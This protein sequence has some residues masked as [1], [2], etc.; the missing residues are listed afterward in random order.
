MRLEA[1]IGDKPELEALARLDTCVTV[2]DTAN[3]LDVFQDHRYSLCVRCWYKFMHYVRFCAYDVES[4]CL[5]A[6][7]LLFQN[8][9]SAR[10]R[11][12]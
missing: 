9:L 10:R 5:N 12:A 8:D 6:P 7:V 2:V 3:F 11:C 4:I 1:V